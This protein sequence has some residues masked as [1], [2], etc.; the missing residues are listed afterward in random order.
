MEDEHTN[1][2]EGEDGKATIALSSDV[3]ELLQENN[4]EDILDSIDMIEEVVMQLAALKL[5]LLNQLKSAAATTAAAA[6]AV[7]QEEDQ[8]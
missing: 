4:K 6:A 7:V 5:H 2:A 8:A 3:K 1:A